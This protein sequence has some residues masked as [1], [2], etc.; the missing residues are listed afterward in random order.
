MGTTLFTPEQVAEKLQVD[1]DT[2]RRYLRSGKLVGV[3]ISRKCWRI[4]AS[5]LYVF[6]QRRKNG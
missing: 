4:E 6:I 5:D 1:I 2:V 3:H